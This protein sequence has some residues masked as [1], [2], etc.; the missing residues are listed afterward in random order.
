MTPMKKA[1]FA[2]AKAHFSEV[3]SDAYH[4]Q[5]STLILRRGKPVAVVVPV[6][7][8]VEAKPKPAGVTKEEAEAFIAS[9]AGLGEPSFNATQDLIDGRR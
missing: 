5:K 9:F 3:V 6:G 1:S 7:S 8:V 2:E 4:H